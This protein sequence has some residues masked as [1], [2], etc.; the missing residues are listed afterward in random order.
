MKKHINSFRFVLYL[1]VSIGF[2]SVFAGA[3]DDFFIAIKRDHRHTVEALLKRGFDPNTLNERAQPGV[4][5]ALRA[6]S[7]EVAEALIASPLLDTEAANPA[8]ET[9]LM[10]A[11]LRGRTDLMERLLKRGAR[12]DRGRLEPLALRSLRTRRKRTRAAAAPRCVGRRSRSPN[13]TTA[14]MMAAQ[15][16]PTAG[17]DVLLEKGADPQLSNDLGMTAADFAQRAGRD[18]LSSRLKT[19]TQKRPPAGRVP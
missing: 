6:E 1:S 5:L 18:R 3:Y 19:L 15:Y 4:V 17:V 11:S 8:G 16:G 7:Y 10:M 13:G 12:V 14:L 9:A 2:S